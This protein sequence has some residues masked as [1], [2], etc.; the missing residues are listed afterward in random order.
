MNQVKLVRA[1]GLR[2]S[3]ALVIGTIIGTGI[4][5]KTAIM[6]DLV[7]SPTL[8]LAA[9]VVAGVLSLA[10]ALTYAEL[11]ELFPRAGGEFVY[12]KEGYGK[13]PAFLYGWQR[14]WIGSPGSIAAYAVGSAT[15]LSGVIPTSQMGGT[16][17]VAIQFILFFTALNCLSVTFGGRLQSLLTAFK[18]AMVVG[19]VIGIFWFSPSASISNFSGTSSAVFSW[20][21]FGAA[22]LAALWAFDGWNNLPMAAG[23]V[24]D[25]SR[26][27]PMALVLGTAIVLL[28]YGVANLSYFFALPFDQILGAYSSKNPNA[29]P[30]ATLAAQGFLGSSGIAVLSIAFVIS[31]LGAMNGSILT[32]ARVPYAMAEED[33]FPKVLGKVSAMTRVPVVAV[34]VQGVWACVLAMSGSFDQLTDY[35]VFAAW[36]FY[37]LNAL[38]VIQF[39]RTLPDAPRRYRVPI[40]IPWIFCI[41]ALILLLNTLLTSPR[42]SVVGLLFIAAGLPVYF[43][44]KK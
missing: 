9:W 18:M 20:S 7:G 28:L 43:L 25:P 26:N 19:M 38:A 44:K 14:F 31:A 34:V 5:L 41:S 1:L 27:I 24:K 12:I 4:F 22:V 10:G 32:S 11:G 29:L 37:G 39:R 3:I 30:V 8:V 40:V 16:T 2:D 23:E 33:L 21:A 17:A 15:F 6:A 13:L 42:E 36:I 35:V